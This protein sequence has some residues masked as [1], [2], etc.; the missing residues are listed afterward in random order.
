MSTA[1]SIHTAHRERGDAPALALFAAAALTYMALDFLGLRGL[2][3]A[4]LKMVPIL[5]LAWLAALRFRGAT[6]GLLLAALGFSALGDLLLALDFPNQFLFGL[7]AF[8]VAQLVYAGNFLRAADFRCRR[9]LWRGLPLLLATWL[10]ARA[11][12][13]AS[14]ELAL[15]VLVY[16]LAILSMALAAAAHRGDSALLYVGALLFVISDSL[17]AVNKFL[18]PLPLAGTWIMLTYYLAQLA[19]L[20]GLA[21]ARA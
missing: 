1:A 21:R 19:L 7:G 15:P 16:L 17:I 3:M 6:R 2:W 9:S 11:L 14:G 12:L 18:Q 20:Y 10:L 5:T 4:L 13:P 8:L